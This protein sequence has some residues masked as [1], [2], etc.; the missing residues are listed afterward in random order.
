MY[1]H[2]VAVDWAQSNMAIARLTRAGQ[3]PHVIDVPADLAEL[4]VYLSNLRGKKILTFEETTTAQW[5][6]VELR[7]LVDEVLVCD[8]YRNKLLSEGPS[9]D[10]I[11]A[12]KLVTLL[13]AGLLKPVFHTSGHF[14]S[15]RKLISGYED[16][17]QRGVR[18]KNQRTA[19]LRAVGKHKT[20][21]SEGLEASDA[22]VMTGLQ[23]AI[24]EY[25]TEK[26]RYEDE[27]SRQLKRSSILRWLDQIP[28]IGPIG[29]VR[30]AGAVVSAERFP[31]RNHFLSY[32][33]L[34]RLDQVSGGRSYGWKN[35]RYRRDLKAVFKTAALS[36]V[37]HDNCF[38]A[39]YRYLI[40]K[41]RYPNHNARHAVAR[42][43]ATAAYGVMKTK[44][45][46]DPYDIG[47][48]RVLLT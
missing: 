40:E 46:F 29:A 2:F 27:F 17:I 18:L 7:G 33:G 8:P 16:L 24:I 19:V 12:L 44:R 25:E 39:Y 13:K 1:D 32:C 36:A 43:I 9:N 48:L 3:R 26:K 11:D 45:K 22:F 34:V 41:K 37:T 30:I 47:A 20:E 42:K 10:R 31:H 15:L 6:Y 38:T 21:N 23:S 35:S 4:K 5:L 28:G 14:I